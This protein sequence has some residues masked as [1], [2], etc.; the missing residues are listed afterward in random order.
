VR[1]EEGGGHGCGRQGRAEVLEEASSRK[2]KLI[3]FCDELR[4]Y[5]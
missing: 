2:H 4:V 5:G 1:G 3:T